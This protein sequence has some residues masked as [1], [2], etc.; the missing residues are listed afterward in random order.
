M[1]KFFK[2]PIVY[3][4]L[5]MVS[6]AILC[7]CFSIGYDQTPLK[8]VFKNPPSPASTTKAAPSPRP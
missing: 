2:R 3:W 6:I 5:I 4:C 1:R 8:S 7:I